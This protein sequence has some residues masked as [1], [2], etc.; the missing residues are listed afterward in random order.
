MGDRAGLLQSVQ[1][2]IRRLSFVTI[3][4]IT[5]I[6]DIVNDLKR[7]ANPIAI[8]SNAGKIRLRRLAKIG[9][10]PNCGSNESACL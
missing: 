9:A 6:Q 7:E 10:N 5:C 1:R 8:L 2:R 4:S 3:M